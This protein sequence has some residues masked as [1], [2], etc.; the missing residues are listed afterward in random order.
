MTGLSLEFL[1]WH[2]AA[3]VAAAAL[4]GWLAL[5]LRRPE[6]DA[7]PVRIRIGLSALRL[8]ALAVLAAALAEPALAW[9]DARNEPPAVAIVIDR[10]GSMG[11]ADPGLAPGARLDEAVALGLIAPGQRPDAAARA[12]RLMRRAG[13]GGDHGS[14]AQLRAL[15]AELAGTPAV[16]SDLVRLAEAV[17][18]G[19]AERLRAAAGMAQQAERIQAEADAA[20]VAGSAADSPLASALS[21][22]ATQPRRE[23][24]IAL[25][26]RIASRLPQAALDW[27]VLDER[28]SPANGP[29]GVRGALAGEAGTDLGEGLASLARGWAGRGHPAACILL[30]DGRR[31]AGADPEPAAR[32]LAA[33]GV[34]LTAIAIG[35]PTPPADVA[36]ASLDAPGE[37]VAGERV[38]LTASVRVPPGAGSWELAWLRDGAEVARTPLQPDPAWRRVESSFPAG[39]PGVALWEARLTPVAGEDRGYGWLREVWTGISAPSL[40][41]LR[42]DPR[43]PDR[44]DERAVVASAMA[45]D[46]RE[47]RGDRMRAWLLPPRDGEYVLWLASDDASELLLSEDGDPAKARAVARVESWSRPEEWDKEPG[48]RSAPVRLRAERPAYVEAVLVNGHLSSHIE[49]GWSRP[50][51]RVERPL[52]LSALVPW[53]PAGPPSR[54]GGRRESTTANNAAARAVAVSAASPR[55]L[56]ADSAPRWEMRHAV[57]ALESGLSARVDRRYRA[58]LGPGANL[59]PDQPALDAFDMLVL[60]DLPPAELGADE[61]ARIGAFASRRGGFVAVVS[62]PRAMPAAYGLGPLAAMLP[63]RS[64]AT[65]GLPEPD[66]G[67]APGTELGRILP[68]LAPAWESLPALPWW[69]RGAVAR[70][71]SDTVLT[72][73]D[74]TGS[75]LLVCADHGAGR[76]A[77]LG[78]DELWRWRG[79]GD[80]ALHAGLWLRLARWGMGARLSGTDHRLQAALDRAVAAPGQAA[81]LR[82]RALDAG[83]APAAAPP[84]VLERIGVDG[85]TIP[86]TRRE[87]A[88]QAVPD[89]PGTWSVAV[90]EAQRPLGEGRWRLSATMAGLGESRELLVRADPGREALEPALDRAALD[91]LASA[92][93][94]AAVGVDEIDGAV[95]ELAAALAPRTITVRHRLTAWDGPWWLLLLALLLVAEWLWR[96]RV[97]LP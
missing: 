46:P 79:A 24:A 89:Q 59:I 11:L 32:S 78:S 29:D 1:G 58:I 38:M 3:A 76:V 56:V 74:R 77:W 91:R 45:V 90:N 9:S 31:T 97:G 65:E 28:L 81:G 60:G 42:G 49:I 22:I 85:R 75:P 95:A 62:G 94:G 63:V 80:G 53:N 40:A 15:A 51:G 8:A 43:W 73:R 54:G 25:A 71:G 61:Q 33:R 68:G 17:E 67:V 83:G 34:R 27:F 52:P 88:L 66:A 39:A 50:D 47:Q 7:L 36:V 44:P 69:V 35:D 4:C 12:A 72:M 5:R 37:A 64:A 10:S 70:P 19:D 48:Q 20:L 82:V 86:G 93:G 16:A 23:R 87:L 14:A 55:I 84:V 6:P 26:E 21:R 2:P 92:T 13:S 41:A 18:T 57:S 96:R 30:S